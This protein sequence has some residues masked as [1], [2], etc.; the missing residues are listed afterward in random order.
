MLN[1]RTG[2]TLLEIIIVIALSAVLS[3][4]GIASLRSFQRYAEIDAAANQIVAVLRE[5]R[6]RAVADSTST[7]YGVHFESGRYV[8]FTGSVYSATSTVN[9]VYSLPPALE[10]YS[11][12][13]GGDSD[14]IFSPLNGAPDAAGSA[15]IRVIEDQSQ[16][17]VIQVFSTGAIGIGDAATSSSGRITDTRH[18]HF[19]FGWSIQNSNTLTLTFANPPNPNVVQ[20]VSMSPYMNADKSKFDWSGSVLVGGEA[21]TIRIHTHLMTASQTKLSI[22]RDRRFNTKAVTISIDGQEIASYASDG[23]A[24]VG[25]FGGTMEI[26]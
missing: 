19:S 21:Q 22:H 17:R 3:T 11:I 24:T 14:V 18:A 7:G 6:D 20:N 15:S 13:L 12:N 26:Q 5:A 8:R 4:I 16:S 25:F 23:T 2:F 10:L 1:A 9:I